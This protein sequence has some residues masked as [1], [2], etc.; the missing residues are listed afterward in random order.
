MNRLFKLSQGRTLRKQLFLWVTIPMFILVPLDTTILY[1][2]G[3]H[4][5]EQSFDEMLEDIANDVIAMISESGKTPENFRMSTESQ[6][7]LFSDKDDKTYFAIYD[8][9]GHYLSGDPTL[10]FNHKDSLNHRQLRYARAHGEVVRLLN[11]KSTI[12]DRQ[13]QPLMYSVL[14][15]ETVHKRNDL[16]S[17]IL[18]AIVLPQLLLL[19]VCSVMLLAGVT[20]G[21]RPL[22]ELNEEIAKRSSTQL[23]P[24]MLNNVPEEAMVLINSINL[25]MGRLNNAIL[26]QNQFIADAAHQLRTPLAGIQA[27]LELALRHEQAKDQS[28][29]QLGMI[30][31]SV[32]KLTHIVNQLLRLSNNQPEAANVIALKPVNL[33]ALAQDACVEVIHF[34][35]KKNID[36]GLE[37]SG[38]GPLPDFT[39]HADKQRLK[40][41]LVNLL[42]NAVRYTPE[43]GKVT[44]S[45]IAQEKWTEI[46]VEDNGIGIPEEEHAMV[47]ERFHRVLNHS[48]EGSGLGLSIVKEIVALH[49][50]SITVSA[51]AQGIGTLM[52]VRFQRPDAGDPAKLS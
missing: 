40:I 2:V 25:L 52:S 33:L 11:Q 10:P 44:L 35:L 41:L 42:D 39:I 29:H 7:V 37:S 51:G 26:A 50:A 46:Q 43:G 38:A 30:S 12:V 13:N 45:V 48:Q 23:D 28:Q 9:Q 31:E 15:A 14:I 3:S 22:H 8:A 1:K 4:F 32:S 27:Q 6:T 49:S 17:R 47:F 5:I 24:V 34:A 19:L 36:L 20:K 16:R 18:F 21:L